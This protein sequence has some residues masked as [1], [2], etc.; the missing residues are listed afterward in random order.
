MWWRLEHSPERHPRAAWLLAASLVALGCSHAL[1]VKNLDRY[2]EPIRLERAGLQSRV[3]VVPYRGPR[4][5]LFFFNAL[6]ERLALSPAIEELRTDYVEEPG[7]AFLPDVVLQIDHRIDYRS[8]ASNFFVNWPGFLIFLPGWIGY[9][10]DADIATTVSIRDARGTLVAEEAIPVAY[11]MRHADMDRTVWAGFG[12]F[13]PLWT[14]TA[15]GGGIYDAVTFDDDVIGGFQAA[16]SD[17]YA[18]YVANRI[19]DRIAAM[20]P[21]ETRTTGSCVVIDRDGTILTAHHIVRD[22]KAIRVLLPSGDWHVAE[23]AHAV[24]AED[25]AV[26][27]IGHRTRGFVPFAP[28][29]T[30]STGLPVF[31]LGHAGRVGAEDD[32]AFTRDTLRAGAGTGL[33]LATPLDAAFDGSPVLSDAG[34]LVG[35]VTSTSAAGQPA[36]VAPVDSVRAA[37]DSFFESAGSDIREHA[38]RRARS[39][40]C[41]VEARR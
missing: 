13:P 23:I 40:L 17:N 37:L 2:Q 36:R 16:V 38:V 25:L 18:Q 31:L 21:V 3:G 6:V 26:L 32:P 27:R 20:A 33:G 24:P 9:G 34:Q 4:E 12:W 7:A 11:H 1:E 5:A 41:F 14:A 19:L 39:A 15:L 28:L 35:I 10:Y 8:S 29:G 22:A 30:A